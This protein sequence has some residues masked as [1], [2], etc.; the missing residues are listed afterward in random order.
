MFR[1]L[2]RVICLLHAA[3]QPRANRKHRG[4][5]ASA[6]SASDVSLLFSVCCFPCA[7]RALASSHTAARTDDSAM[8]EETESSFVKLID[9]QTFDVLET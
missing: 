6:R 8:G 9:F 7:G 2:A 5:S 4:R 3:H 1:V